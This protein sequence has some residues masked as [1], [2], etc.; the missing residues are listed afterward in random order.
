MKKLF[1]AI[2]DGKPLWAKSQSW[3]LMRI[4][5]I[6]FKGN[7]EAVEQNANNETVNA[8][9]GDGFTPL[10]FAIERSK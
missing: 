9:D 10:Y 4:S 7:I 8:V 2:Q 6:L 3:N 1:A 5:D